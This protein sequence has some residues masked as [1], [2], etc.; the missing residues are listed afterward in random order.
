MS[1]RRWLEFRRKCSG[2]IW[3]PTPTARVFVLGAPGL[4]GALLAARV[5]E[6]WPG[7]AAGGICLGCHRAVAVASREQL[8]GG[9]SVRLRLAVGAA[10]CEHLGVPQG[11]GRNCGGGGEWEGGGQKHLIHTLLH[12]A[13]GVKP[14]TVLRSG[15]DGA[16]DGGYRLLHAVE[17]GQSVGTQSA[18]PWFWPL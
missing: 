5:A 1:L 10:S 7:A 2:F 4:L 13:V 17:K 9:G 3:L 14:L 6:L 8:L 16:D 18:L 11:A 12:Q 15:A